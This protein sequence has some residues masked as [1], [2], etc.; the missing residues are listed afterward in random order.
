MPPETGKTGLL[1]TTQVLRA[2]MRGDTL[3][4]TS[5]RGKTATARLTRI[6]SGGYN[7]V[8][9][10]R[11]TGLVVRVSKGAL[12]PEEQAM[13]YRELGVQRALAAEA[14]SP[15]VFAVLHFAAPGAACSFAEDAYETDEQIGVCMVRFDCTL[16]DVLVSAEKTA[17]VFV[18]FDG[19]NALVQLLGRA[20][21]IATCVDTKAANVVVQLRPRV[22][23]ALIDVDV[24]FCGV[25]SRAAPK[26]GLDVGWLRAELERAGAARRGEAVLGGLVAMSLLILC[27][28]AAPDTEMGQLRR[29]ALALLD[30]APTVMRLVADDEIAALA[31]DKAAF[32]WMGASESVFRQLAHYTPVRRLADIEARL[33]LAAREGAGARMLR[34]CSSPP[35]PALFVA[36]SAAAETR[37]LKRAL[38]K[39]ESQDEIRRI[40]HMAP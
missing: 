6:S 25:K 38:S 9:A 14:L 17:R 34:L 21:S 7:T 8:Y 2:S 12:T 35:D 13:Y 26:A 15:E 28:E 31:R 23:F 11:G 4:V 29:I 24:H 39:A 3:T 30:H 32:S 36:A 33:A 10:A 22:A 5:A 18:E 20:A 16:G 37:A 19:E 1:R 40:V 27:L